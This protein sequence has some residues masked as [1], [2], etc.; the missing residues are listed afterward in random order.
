[1]L[2]PDGLVELP[3]IPPLLLGLLPVSLPRLPLGDEPSDAQFTSASG[4]AMARAKV[5]ITFFIST[6]PD[7]RRPA[8]IPFA[9]AE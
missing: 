4:I 6:P 2:L 3:P 9:V 1:M 8:R 5:R 7:V